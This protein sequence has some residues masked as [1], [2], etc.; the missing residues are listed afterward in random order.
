MV[1]YINDDMI[2]MVMMYTIR[3][4]DDVILGVPACAG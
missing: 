1:D 3:R 2:S 4:Y